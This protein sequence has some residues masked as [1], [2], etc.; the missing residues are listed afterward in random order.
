MRIY[1]SRSGKI[2]EFK[3][4]KEEEEVGIYICGPTVYNKVHIGNLRTFIV[5]DMTR[6][7][8]KY[9]GY[10]VKYVMNITDIDDKIM[11]SLKEGAKMEEMKEYTE[12]YKNLFVKDMETLKMEKPQIE[13][14]TDNMDSVIEMIE[15]IVKK[16]YGYKTRDGSVYYDIT[17]DKNYGKGLKIKMNKMLTADQREGSRQIFKNDDLRSENDFVL[18]KPPHIDYPLLAWDSIYGKGRP[19][20][21]IECSA[22]AKKHLSHLHIHL[23]GEDLK[24]PHHTNEI[25]QCECG[26][27]DRFG[28]FWMH[29]KFVKLNGSKISKSFGNT[30]YLDD[31]INLGYSPEVIR[32]Y[33]LN[34][35]YRKPLDFDIQHLDNSKNT[36]NLYYLSYAKLQLLITLSSSYSQLEL[37]FDFNKLKNDMDFSLSNDF[38]IES[39]FTHFTKLSTFIRNYSYSES[40]NTSH[41]NYIYD[42]LNHLDSILNIFV[43]DKFTIPVE[44]QKLISSRELFRSQSDFVQS[45]NI[46]SIIN[47]HGY[48][49]IDDIIGPIVFKL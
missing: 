18:W 6:K 8:L 49:I 3:V 2:E 16:E 48:S 44:I 10:K 17:K 35:N 12:K 27:D 36:L 43:P 46:R 45:D 30:P 13:K 11:K 24:F 40:L 39:F 23:G 4:R 47:S 26:G 31:I 29:V 19:G 42:Y 7:V 5:G 20:W 33:L 37:P 38:D 1:N 21:H 15:K 41:L 25:A 14:V 34:K 32:Y 22:I 9:K 28:D